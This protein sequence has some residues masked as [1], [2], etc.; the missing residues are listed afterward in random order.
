M[1]GDGGPNLSWGMFWPGWW[2]VLAVVMVLALLR[3]APE[4]GQPILVV[5]VLLV[6]LDAAQQGLFPKG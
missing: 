5:V 4:F 3:W 2:W 6:L 1:T